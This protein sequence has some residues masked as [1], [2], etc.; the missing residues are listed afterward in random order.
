[1]LGTTLLPC[2]ACLPVPAEL[3]TTSDQPCL[4]T[5]PLSASSPNRQALAGSDVLAQACQAA[6]PATRPGCLIAPC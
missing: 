3:A 4:S 5:A 2:H 1:M 6:R